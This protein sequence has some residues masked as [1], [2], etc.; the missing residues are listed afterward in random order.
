MADDVMTNGDNVLTSPATVPVALDMVAMVIFPATVVPILVAFDMGI[1]P[2]TVLDT[3]A[4]VILPA[5]VLVSDALSIF[6]VL[7]P[8]E[9]ASS[10][11]FP[12]TV[13]TRVTIERPAHTR[14]NQR[15]VLAVAITKTWPVDTFDKTAT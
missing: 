15:S 9:S 2:A 7:F 1:F 10:L 6:S 4:S 5:T 11:V 14:I 13:L 12:V 8:L 3:V